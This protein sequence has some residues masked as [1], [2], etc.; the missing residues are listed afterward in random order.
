[1]KNYKIKYDYGY[2]AM[3]EEVEAENEESA[4]RIAYE[5]WREAAKDNADYSVLGEATDELREDYLENT[6]ICDSDNT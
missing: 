3:Y 4:Q 1:M 6:R 5:I 2:G